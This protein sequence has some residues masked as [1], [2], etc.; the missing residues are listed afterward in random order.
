MRVATAWRRRAVLAMLILLPSLA[1]ARAAPEPPATLQLL[2]GG[3]VSLDQYR[4]RLLVLN[5]WATWCAPCRGE[6]AELD[7]YAR[8]HVGSVAVIAVLAE[9]RPDLRLVTAHAA[10]LRLPIALR[11]T[12][13]G[14]S[15]PLVNSA[16]PTTYVIDR[17]GRV[18]LRR[19]GAFAP[20]E[21]P[22]RLDAL[23][24]RRLAR[25]PGAATTTVTAHVATRETSR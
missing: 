8:A 20:G 14:G 17:T 11:F 2:D 25:V 21:L 23:L 13:G 22:A 3:S 6:L 1:V 4:G 16:V 7:A 24:G 9:R 15:F 5:F 19:G 12:A 10:A 18:V